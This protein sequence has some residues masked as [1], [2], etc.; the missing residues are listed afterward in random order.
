M[1]LQ[2]EVA[3]WDELTA[4]E[5]D[6]L[7]A[8]HVMGWHLY[9]RYWWTEGK[10]SPP[11]G[12]C[13]G[14][15]EYGWNPATDHNDKTEAVRAFGDQYTRTGSTNE[16]EAFVELICA[17]NAANDMATWVFAMLE[18]DPADVCRAMLEALAESEDGHE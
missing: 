16:C 8:V 18:L 1:S 3:R 12:H 6:A 4:A 14:K 11:Q 5:R 2:S 15:N 7:V 17:S 13:T 10:G 9:Y